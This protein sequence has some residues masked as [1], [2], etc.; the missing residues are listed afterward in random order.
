MKEERTNIVYEISQEIEHKFPTVLTGW[1][2]Y[3]SIGKSLTN[4]GFKERLLK[5]CDC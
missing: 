4:K 2:A 1:V 3:D 5:S